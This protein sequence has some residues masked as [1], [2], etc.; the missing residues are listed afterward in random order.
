MKEW[1]NA[2]KYRP[3]DIINSADMWEIVRQPAHLPITNYPWDGLNVMTMGIRAGEIVTMVAGTGSGKSTFIKNC[4]GH[5]LKRD[6]DMNLGVFSLEEGIDS[7]AK[8]IMS[9]GADVCT[10]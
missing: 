2:P 8:G 4:I 5:I 6:P 3:S 1:W 9:R 7:A 10:Q